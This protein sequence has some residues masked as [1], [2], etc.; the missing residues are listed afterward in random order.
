MART[1]DFRRAQRQRVI[2]RRLRHIREWT[3]YPLRP[4]GHDVPGRWAKQDPYAHGRCTV[5]RTDAHEARDR[6]QK[7]LD[8]EIAKEYLRSSRNE[9]RK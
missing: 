9:G 1:R 6:M 3:T 7:R 5:C 4:W 2:T 8:A